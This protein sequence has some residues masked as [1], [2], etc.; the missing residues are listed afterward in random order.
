MSSTATGNPSAGET[1]VRIPI[2][3]LRHRM[4]LRDMRSALSGIR[5]FVQKSAPARLAECRSTYRLP[6]RNRR[7]GTS[8]T[9]S[10]YVSGFTTIAICG[11]R[12]SPTV[13][14]CR[15]RL[16]RERS[17]PNVSTAAAGFAKSLVRRSNDP[18]D[19][20]VRSGAIDQSGHRFRRR[21]PSEI[22]SR[23]TPSKLSCPI[24]AMSSTR[25]PELM[26]PARCGEVDSD[27]RTRPRLLRDIGRLRG[28]RTS[29]RAL[30]PAW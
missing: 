29:A 10:R 26:R 4:P 16:N 18:G 27:R 22:L 5:L 20:V 23:S 3:P 19:V 14:R 7:P 15:M 25:Q 6:P 21:A 30:A 1:A 8:P 13:H 12:P 11:E 28:D 17:A 9:A 2:R 24:A